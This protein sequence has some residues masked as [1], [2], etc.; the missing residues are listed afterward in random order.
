[1]IGVNLFPND[2][3]GY[4]YGDYVRLFTN[5]LG[6]VM[7]DTSLSSGIPTDTVPEPASLLLLLGGVG[8]LAGVR[9]RYQGSASTTLAR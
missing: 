5:V 7:P 3:Y 6:G 2:A 4:V 9:K 8:L 1:M